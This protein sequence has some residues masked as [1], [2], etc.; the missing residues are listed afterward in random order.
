MLDAYKA[1]MSLERAQEL[2]QEGDGHYGGDGFGGAVLMFLGHGFA[3]LSCM[4]EYC[5]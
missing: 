3:A 5:T 2:A 1:A 4:F